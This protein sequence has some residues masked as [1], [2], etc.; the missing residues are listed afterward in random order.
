MADWT[1]KAE[2]A[3]F[4][5]PAILEP[6]HAG[7]G[8]PAGPD[9]PDRRQGPRHTATAA[10]TTPAPWP[11]SSPAASRARPTAPTSVP[12]SRSIRWRPRGSAIRPGCPRWKSAAS[13]ARWPATATP[14]IAASTPRPCPGARPRRRCPRKST[15]SWSSSGSSATART[16]SGP[17]ATRTARACSTSSARTPATCERK[18]GANDQRKLDEYFT[19]VRDIELRIERAEKLPPV[20][21]ARL[22]RRRPACRPSYDEHIRLMCDL[23][24]LAFQADVTRV[25][26]FVFANEG[27]NRP[28]PFIGVPEGHHDLSHHGNDAEEA[29]EDPRHQH[30]PRQAARLPARRS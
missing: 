15:R 3:D 28:Y 23:M 7:E 19:S 16:P 11:R 14:A 13:T 18:L 17:S 6:L 9:R 22:C 1:P 26:T 29:G 24:V 30:L 4:E 21:D 27:S 2:G 5:L 25:C 20:Q 8:R 10:A 12:A